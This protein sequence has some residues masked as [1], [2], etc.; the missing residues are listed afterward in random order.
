MPTKKRPVPEKIL[1]GNPPHGMPRRHL[2][3]AEHF[4]VAQSE[5]GDS[6]VTHDD[7]QSSP[8]HG[9]FQCPGCLHYTVR[10]WEPKA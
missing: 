4:C 6:T 8:P 7:W 2:F 10:H 5:A 1:C 9:T 3:I